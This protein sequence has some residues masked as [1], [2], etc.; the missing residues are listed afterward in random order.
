MEELFLVGKVLRS[1]T[2]FWVL[3]LG[4]S[5]EESLFQLLSGLLLME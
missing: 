2:L 1:L 5:K 3:F 4:L